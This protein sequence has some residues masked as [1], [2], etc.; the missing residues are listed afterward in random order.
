MKQQRRQI[1]Y[2]DLYDIFEMNVR[3][4]QNFLNGLV[5]ICVRAFRNSVLKLRF[6]FP[7]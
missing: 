4:E 3:L 5:G 7:A 1:W 6:V 2:C